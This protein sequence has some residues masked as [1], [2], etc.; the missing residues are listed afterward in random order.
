MAYGVKSKYKRKYARKG[1]VAKLAKG[2]TTSVQALAKAVK[3]IQRS[4]RT[5][6]EYLNYRVS[7]NFGIVGDYSAISLSNYSGW[8]DIF[9]SAANDDT[10]NKMIHKSFGMDCYLSLENTINEPDTTQFTIFLVSLKDNIGSNAFNSSTGA[11]SLSS[12]VHYSINGGL[13]LLNKKCFSIHATKRCVLTNHG[14]ALTA[15]SAQTQSGTDKRF[16]MKW[17]PNA[18]ITNTQ[19][20]WK[21]LACSPDPSKQ[22]FLLI[23]SDNSAVDLQNPKF[24]YNV[25]HTV[26]T[27]A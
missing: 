22:Y 17:R 23:F 18:M 21:S 11:L 5:R 14:T 1:R 8:T 2:K 16:Y 24:S 13:A 15:P 10:Q 25:V 3:S 19:G 20:D 27:V 26:Q 7:D 12:G 6:T 9:G 4:M